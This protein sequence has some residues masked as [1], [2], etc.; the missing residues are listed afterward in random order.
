MTRQTCCEVLLGI[1]AES[2]VTRS[3]NAH[4]WESFKYVLGGGALILGRA[5]S[6]PLF[7]RGQTGAVAA[8]FSVSVMVA[9]TTPASK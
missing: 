5:C 7:L 9:S 6:V 3:F 8:R 1:L 4:L 2:P